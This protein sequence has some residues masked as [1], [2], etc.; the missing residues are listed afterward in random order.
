MLH[1]RSQLRSTSEGPRTGRF[2]VTCLLALLLLTSLAV[3]PA[4][5]AG[6]PTHP[7][8]ASPQPEETPTPA[9]T[10]TPDEVLDQ[11]KREAL[12]ADE[13]KKK[14]IADKDRAEAENAKLKAVTQP[15]GAAS[16]TI[17]T[18][19]VQTDA[20]GWVESQMLAQ[21][22]ARQITIGLAGKLCTGRLLPGGVAEQLPSDA[23]GPTQNINTLV[24]Y[25]NDD[26]GGVELY[27]TVIGQLGELK[28]EFTTENPKAVTILGNTNPRAPAVA[29]AVFPLL[30]APAIATGAI[31]S[32]AEILNLFRTDTS[33]Q[34]KSVQISEDM[35]V[36]HIVDY[37]G[38]NGMV[39]PG[40]V[41]AAPVAVNSRCAQSIRVYY[42]A[43]FPPNLIRSTQNSTVLTTLNQVQGLRNTAAL[44][45]EQTDARIKDITGLQALLADKKKKSAAQ[46]AKTASLTAKEAELKKCTATADC[47]RIRAEIKDL[48]KDIADL[49]KSI[50]DIDGDLTPNIVANEPNFKQWLA[51]LNELKNKI[52]ARITATDVLAAKL[53]SP[54]PT[55]KLTALA[56]LLRAEK[57][58][59]ILGDSQTFT[60]RVA[61]N[62]NG[63]TKIKKNMFVDA[64]VRHSAGAN[65]VYQ[66]FN[67]DG[68]L[69]QGDV[70]QCYISYQSS[71]DVQGVMSGAKTVACKPN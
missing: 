39:P 58:N 2:L 41:A 55:S 20:A 65:V 28:T 56:Q 50:A 64:K 32:V 43:L 42:P 59:G 16:V 30:A 60:L 66:L 31:K 40:A 48:K 36:S 14:A 25:N 34:N 27:V 13:L 18:G 10:P 54:D 47:N 6:H 23:A 4:A 17:P 61:V 51:T 70:M 22:A 8:A 9:P 38:D 49:V 21:E 69:A 35:V 33:F 62:A 45:L 53:T 11:A 1:P 67:R 63:T 7:E 12:I 37:F 5:L 46:T 3:V 26:L 19:S 24:I 52:Q 29:L 44:L 15:L 68:V 57:L 71:Q